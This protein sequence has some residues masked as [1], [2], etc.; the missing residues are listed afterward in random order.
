MNSLR[1]PR[2]FHS[3]ACAR[4]VCRL[5]VAL[6]GTAILAIF[7]NSAKADDSPAFAG[8][9][10]TFGGVAWVWLRA[11]E[12]AYG[13]TD[14]Y[15]GPSGAELTVSGLLTN[16]QSYYVSSNSSVNGFVDSG[17]FYNSVEEE[18]LAGQ[19]RTIE[20]ATYAGITRTI[21]R[22]W[23][24]PYAGMVTTSVESYDFLTISFGT[25]GIGEITGAR[26]GF[27]TN[28]TYLLNSSEPISSTPV[29]VPDLFGNT[30]AFGEGFLDTRYSRDG[31]SQTLSR[32]HY[33]GQAGAAFCD[34]VGHVSDGIFTGGLSGN[35][36]A[37]GSITGSV[38]MGVFTCQA[39][40]TAPS[41]A[42][43][44]LYLN[45][46]LIRWQSGEMAQDGMVTDHYSGSGSS[47]SMLIVGN[48]Q[49]TGSTETNVFITNPAGS[50]TFDPATQQFSVPDHSVQI[51]TGNRSNPI[52]SSARSL[53]V[54]GSEYVFH[55]GFSS[56]EGSLIDEY[57]HEG[58]GR[59]TL[60]AR[61]Q[62][63][64]I[65]VALSYQE[66]G[67]TGIYASPWF[68]MSGG[69][70]VNEAIPGA[71]A[72]FWIDGRLYYR[73]QL[74]G[75]TYNDRSNRRC[76]L[77]GIG[78]NSSLSGSDGV[79][80][81]TGSMGGFAGL[82]PV[83]FSDGSVRLGCAAT[84]SG[85]AQM[86]A[87]MRPSLL[88]PALAVPQATN[89]WR[90]LGTIGG[91]ENA[92][93]YYADAGPTVSENIGFNFDKS[94]ILAIDPQSGSV[95][96]WNTT[97]GLTICSGSYDTSRHLFQSSLENPLP[98]LIFGVDPLANGS[99]WNLATPPSG[100]PAAVI[101]NG[102]TW[103]YGEPGAGDTALYFGYYSGQVLSIGPAGRTGR[104]VQLADA[105]RADENGNPYQE[106]GT[107][108][109]GSFNMAGGTAIKAGQING[110]YVAPALGADHLET[111]TG[112]LD[113]RGGILSLGSWRPPE[114]A[115]AGLT[116]EYR[117]TP[118]HPATISLTGSRQSTSWLWSHA[119]SDGESNTQRAMLLGS[120]NALTLY[121]P[122]PVDPQRPK[123]IEL[124][125]GGISDIHGVLRVQPGGDIPMFVPTN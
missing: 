72:A 35:D 120:G 6:L 118:G 49:D 71:P 117:E 125:P 36:P 58:L 121:D 54:N 12:S 53:Y 96:Y 108:Y 63:V 42:P 90:F 34:L 4:W 32:L 3:L 50:G 95:T 61:L 52:F 103:L 68:A 22:Y 123:N 78:G 112:D 44:F 67:Y 11:E 79:L 20:N 122:Q 94:K 62:T 97:G 57:R 29:A 28:G 116:I 38:T 102:Q 85:Q 1:F 86:S 84:A 59:L 41:I 33:N 15:S 18:S 7:S 60:T 110:T 109:N 37:I 98:M 40:R 101:V 113:I 69:V 8:T 23:A 46:K 82:F 104:D 25:D 47:S 30:Y 39:T 16:L 56:A 93:A 73:E 115:N 45:G 70:T 26:T 91:V 13:H 106:G 87:Q 5:W 111:V 2:W 19:P 43:G 99:A 21:S 64:D 77:S 83:E 80:S 24:Q 105:T 66:A 10:P 51:A 76:T 31:S 55:Q 88:P 119:I 9:S 89:P 17:T 114:S 74:N 14:Y 81:Y 27:V 124:K 92:T 100:R 107:F 48:L 65:A 75:P